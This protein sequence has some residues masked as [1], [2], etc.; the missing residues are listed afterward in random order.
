[1]PAEM[2]DPASEVAL[3]ALGDAGQQP[4]AGPTASGRLRLAGLLAR[5]SEEQHGLRLVAERVTNPAA[6]AGD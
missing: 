6:A 3:A 4:W 5:L 1:V 2:I